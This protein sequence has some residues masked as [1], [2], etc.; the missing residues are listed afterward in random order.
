MKKLLVMCGSGIATSTVVMGKVKTWLEE[1]GYDKNV[2]LYQSKIAEEVN[3]IDDYDI[4]IS[5]T[6]VPESVQD[7][8]IMGL[9]LLTGI[10]A[11]ALWEEVK[12]EIEA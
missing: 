7:K 12:K 4:V 11:D 2:K 5:T 8:V 1:N 6:V 9:P 3:H 10:G